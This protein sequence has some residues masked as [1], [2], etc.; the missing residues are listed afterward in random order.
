MVSLDQKLIHKNCLNATFCK[1]KSF[2]RSKTH[3][4]GNFLTSTSNFS[5]LD[6]LVLFYSQ[7]WPFLT[8]WKMIFNFRECT[9]L[10]I[11]WRFGKLNFTDLSSLRRR[12]RRGCQSTRGCRSTWGCR[13]IIL[14]HWKL[15]N[16]DQACLDHLH[17]QL[18]T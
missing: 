4:F 9:I 3:L 8:I 2:L 11:L 13:S 10:P 5:F 12:S 16:N 17:V 7:R 18:L 1:Q 14:N 6:S 15:I